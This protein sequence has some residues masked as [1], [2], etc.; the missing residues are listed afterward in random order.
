MELDL[1]SPAAMPHRLPRLMLGA[2]GIVY[3]DIGT[4]PLYTLREAFGHSGGLRL[5]EVN[6]LGVLSLIF[7]ALM[8]IVTLKYAVVIMGYAGIWVMTG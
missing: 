7:W 5:T 8:I 2:I 1:Q 3:G 6:V 4:S